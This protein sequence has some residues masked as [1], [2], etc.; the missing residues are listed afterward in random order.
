MNTPHGGPARG[1]RARLAIAAVLA[2]VIV[3]GSAWARPLSDQERASLSAT[4]ESYNTAVRAGDYAHMAQSMPPKIVGAVA[5]RVGKSSD[6]VVGLM[7]KAIEQTLQGGAVKIESFALDLGNADHKELASGAP[8]VL[9][10]T[11]TTIAVGGRRVRERSLTLALLDG[12]KW[13]LLRINSAAQVQILRDG[14][15]DFTSVEF[16][17]GSMEDLNP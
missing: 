17:S 8:Y 6:Q 1:E 2:L 14:Y 3:A 10:P 16:P 15:P 9:I 4:I 12:G 5:V 11:E 7:T 13:F